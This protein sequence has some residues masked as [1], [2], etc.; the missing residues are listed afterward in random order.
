MSMKVFA[1]LLLAALL[2]VATT[3]AAE[4]DG[5]DEFMQWRIGNSYGALSEEALRQF[6]D[7]IAKHTLRALDERASGVIQLVPRSVGESLV[8]EDPDTVEAAR[9]FFETQGDIVSYEN[10]GNADFCAMQAVYMPQGDDLK[11]P[12]LNLT[13]YG[14]LAIL[15]RDCPQEET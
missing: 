10:R 5:M 15:A 6:I 3:R 2:A 1:A 8:A 13:A 4:V 7:V 11:K 12:A 14:N 9:A